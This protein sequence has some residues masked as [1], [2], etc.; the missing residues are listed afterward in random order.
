MQVP[1]VVG[2]LFVLW[3]HAS[4]SADV[5]NVLVDDACEDD[6][7]ECGVSLR[8]LRG[9]FRITEAEERAEMEAPPTDDG[10]VTSDHEEDSAELT[11]A[12]LDGLVQHDKA[13]NVLEGLDGSGQKV[14]TEGGTQDVEGEAHAGVHEEDLLVLADTDGDGEVQ[15]LEALHFVDS[16]RNHSHGESLALFQAQDTD[17]SKGLNGREFA[18]A[19]EAWASG[20]ASRRVASFCVGAARHCCCFHAGRWGSC[21]CHG[22]VATCGGGYHSGGRYGY[23]TPYGGGGGGYRRGP[24]GGGRYHYHYGYR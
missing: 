9:E 23:H 4:A 6:E 5:E 24:Y 18:A 11:D 13:E 12:D 17:S 15:H 20:C 8:Q 1:V 10:V 3:A 14:L 16:L 21:G 2:W 19:L 22:H 7:G